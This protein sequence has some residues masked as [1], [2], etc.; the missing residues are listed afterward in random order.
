VHRPKADP[1][2]YAKRNDPETIE[3]RVYLGLKKLIVLRKRYAAFAAGDLT[4]IR[5]ENEHVLGFIR[6]CDAD[7]AMIFANFSETPQTIRSDV[8]E[9]LP[10]SAWTPIYGA[11]EL[12][13]GQNLEIAPLEFLALTA[14]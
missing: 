7:R 3:G 12:R 11:T 14:A 2:R 10:L 4:I 6:T 8:L 1:E 13:P 5:T 9:N